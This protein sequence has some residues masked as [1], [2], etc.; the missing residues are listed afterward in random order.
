MVNI[1][2]D[3]NRGTRLGMRSAHGPTSFT[4][5]NNVSNKFSHIPRSPT[6][7]PPSPMTW[8]GGR[9]AN[10]GPYV[11]LDD[12][13]D[14]EFLNEPAEAA[15]R[16]LASAGNTGLSSPGGF[17]SL[18]VNTGAQ[19]ESD[20]KPINLSMY[21]TKLQQKL[22]LKESSSGTALFRTQKEEMKR[23]HSHK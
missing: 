20:N 16:M 23:S 8:R 10:S 1:V 21:E 6:P 2:S 22:G 11:N 3:L 9:G 14:D 17:P 13:S 15:E 18:N 7:G 19:M 12:L 5:N 4:L